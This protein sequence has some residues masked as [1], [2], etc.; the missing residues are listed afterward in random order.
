MLENMKFTNVTVIV[1]RSIGIRGI[2]I[3]RVGTGYTQR[4]LLESEA[5]PS[6]GGV[7]TS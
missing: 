4:N 1:I 5:S 3:G 7:D 6:T 2:P